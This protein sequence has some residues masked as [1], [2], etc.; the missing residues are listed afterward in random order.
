M[1]QPKFFN[2]LTTGAVAKAVAP[3][4]VYTNKRLY[5]KGRSYWYGLDT[6]IPSARLNIPANTTSFTV[7]LRFI[8]STERIQSILGAVEFYIDKLYYH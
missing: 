6:P 1:N 7:P 5:I 8:A 2:R 4:I 3:V